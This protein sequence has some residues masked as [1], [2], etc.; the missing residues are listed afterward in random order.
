MTAEN[1]ARAVPVFL[2]VFLGQMAVDEVVQ[3]GCQRGRTG[4]VQLGEQDQ[5]LVVGEYRVS[6]SVG[7]GACAKHLVRGG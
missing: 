5:A 2:L 3:C 6:K 1:G 7:V 4:A